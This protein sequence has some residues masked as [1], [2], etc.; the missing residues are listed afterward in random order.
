MSN[1]PETPVKAEAAGNNDA[2]EAPVGA[3]ATAVYKDGSSD[4]DSSVVFNDVDASPYSGVVFEQPA[5]PQPAGFV[6]FGGSFMDS[7]VAT[8]DCSSLS[9]SFGTKWQHGSVTY[10]CDSYKAGSYGFAEEWLAGSDVVNSDGA[11]GFFADE[12]ASNLNF[13]WCANGAGGWD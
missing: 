11:A 2:A 7:S 10:P 8:M 4:S 1:K 5:P 13:S 12:H 9:S 3:S 6:G